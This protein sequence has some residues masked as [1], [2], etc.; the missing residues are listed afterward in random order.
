MTHVCPKPREAPFSGVN[1]YIEAF[2]IDNWFVV[3]IEVENFRPKS[4]LAHV[5]KTSEK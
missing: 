4:N 3:I 2:T 5:I 1:I